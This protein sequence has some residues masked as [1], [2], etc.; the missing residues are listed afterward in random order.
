MERHVLFSAYIQ[1]AKWRLHR[2]SCEL[3]AT[4]EEWTLR[5][6]YISVHIEEHEFITEVSI[7]NT[8]LFWNMI[9]V[10]S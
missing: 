3:I 2:N 6:F 10:Y 9:P 8:T 1:A 7:N 4:C 5:Y